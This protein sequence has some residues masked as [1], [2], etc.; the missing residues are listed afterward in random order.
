MV[1]IFMS[2]KEPLNS[3]QEYGVGTPSVCKV[4]LVTVLLSINSVKLKKMDI[5]TT[6]SMFSNS[7]K[8]LG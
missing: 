4:I 6:I 7:L 3:A 1:N 2:G 8:L 5:L